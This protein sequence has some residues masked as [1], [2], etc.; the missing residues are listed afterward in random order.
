MALD[1][2]TGYQGKNHVTAEQWA[3]FNRGVYGDAA[4]LPIGN[5]MQVEIQTANQITVKDGT[6][7]FDGRQVYF[8]YG[9][10]ENI[11]IESGTQE[12][13]RNDIVVIEYTKDESTGVE[14]AA[15]KVIAGTPAASDPADPSYQDMDIRTGVFVSQKPFCRV[16]L[17]GVA[18]EGVDMLVEVKEFAAHAFQPP[19]AN[20]TTTKPGQAL[21]ATMGKELK[22]GFDQLNSRIT[23]K[24]IIDNIQLT[25][26]P[27]GYSEPDITLS[28]VTGVVAARVAQLISF[29]TGGQIT[30]SIPGGNKLWV[31]SEVAQSVINLCVLQFYTDS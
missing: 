23:Y 7:V 3:D 19:A 27:A 4:I 25:N 24:C 16:R 8:G 9:E 14:S 11:A 22:E 15:F 18:I 1:L 21:D 26:V 28:P 29:S 17:N 30:I 20:L 6:G 13:L 31:V 10:S 12:M 2:V 5:R